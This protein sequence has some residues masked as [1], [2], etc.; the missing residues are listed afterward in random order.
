MKL[1]Q[2]LQS[3]STDT[4]FIYMYCAVTKKNGIFDAKLWQNKR[5]SDVGILQHVHFYISMKP[6][7]WIWTI[8]FATCFEQSN[9]TK[10]CS[11]AYIFFK[12]YVMVENAAKKG[13]NSD[14][15]AVFF[16]S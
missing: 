16:T 13:K 10:N 8:V 1:D 14:D 6:F 11:S 4:T 9:V 3:V 15:D 2:P 7:I 5:F 12:K